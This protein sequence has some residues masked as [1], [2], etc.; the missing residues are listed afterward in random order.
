[1]KKLSDVSLKTQNGSITIKAEKFKEILNNVFVTAIEGG[2]TYWMSI[3]FSKVPKYPGKPLSE[4]T[5]EYILEG[6]SVAVYD[7][8][9][10]DEKLGMLSLSSIYDGIKKID[11]HMMWAVEAEMGDDFDAESSDVLMQHFVMGEVVYG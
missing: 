2:S 11:Y 7:A 4:C 10:D 1:M 9:D 3:D 6:G 8:E 5:L